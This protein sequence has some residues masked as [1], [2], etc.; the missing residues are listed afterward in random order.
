MSQKKLRA[1]AARCIANARASPHANMQTISTTLKDSKTP[2]KH[3]NL[4]YDGRTEENMQRH[5]LWAVEENRDLNN[6]VNLW[7]WV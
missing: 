6:E 5:S 4:I 3:E 7:V 1:C 2:V